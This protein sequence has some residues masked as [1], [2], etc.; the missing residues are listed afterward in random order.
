MATMSMRAWSLVEVG[1]WSQIRI[2]RLEKSMYPRDVFVRYGGLHRTAAE[3]VLCQNIAMYLISGM[4]SGVRDSTVQYSTVQLSTEQ[5][6]E[7]VPSLELGSLLR[8]HRTPLV[9]QGA[10]RG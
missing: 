9:Y 6:L 7:C 4:E 8:R 1:Q 5:Y 10:C 3:V 2:L